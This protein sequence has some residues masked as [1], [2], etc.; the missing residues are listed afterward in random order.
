MEAQV[1]RGEARL[2]DH[3]TNLGRWLDDGLAHTSAI[4]RLHDTLDRGTIAIL[5]SGLGPH[6]TA[7]RDR[8]SS[9][10]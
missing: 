7:Q 1:E 10:S 4:G 3:C 9:L 2:L 5:R 6:P 8:L